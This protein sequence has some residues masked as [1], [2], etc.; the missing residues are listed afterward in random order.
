MNAVERGMELM[1]TKGRDLPLLAR[2]FV[3]VLAR[4]AGG[5]CMEVVLT[6]YVVY[7]Q[8]VDGL[9]C[10]DDLYMAHPNHREWFAKAAE[11]RQKETP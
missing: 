7:A 10:D 11:C 3:P 4:E 2:E 5:I 8:C 6:A 9:P 1:T